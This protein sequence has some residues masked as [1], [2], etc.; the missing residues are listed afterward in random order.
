MSPPHGHASSPIYNNPFICLDLREAYYSLYIYDTNMSDAPL[1]DDSSTDEETRAENQRLY[2]SLRT[3]IEERE[4]GT[5]PG[6]A[7]ATTAALTHRRA[8]ANPV[9]RRM[10]QG[11]SIPSRPQS[12]VQPERT[13]S[14][15]TDRQSLSPPYPVPAIRTR[16]QNQINPIIR[17]RNPVTVTLDRRLQ[18]HQQPVTVTSTRSMTPEA[19]ALRNPHLRPR[20]IRHEHFSSTDMAPQLSRLN[21][22]Q[23]ATPPSRVT[24]TFCVIS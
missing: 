22:T 6:S 2:P 17:T 23:F 3:T 5:I 7:Q 8:Q 10:N 12:Y 1:S 13:Q 21:Q 20:L 15:I 14:Q 19:S 18:R 4:Y 24:S 9:V 16:P 11:R